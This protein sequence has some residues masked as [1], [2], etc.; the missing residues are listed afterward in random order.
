M[1]VSS[2]VAREKARRLDF[3]LKELA[4]KIDD[5]RL[6]IDNVRLDIR[7][8]GPRLTLCEIP[9][10]V[11]LEILQLV[12]TDMLRLTRM[13]HFKTIVNMSLVC[14]QFRRI[15]LSSS[16]LWAACT[17]TLHMPPHIIDMVVSR[18]GSNGI[19]VELMDRPRLSQELPLSSL[20]KLFEH[21]S[22]WRELEIELSDE[23]SQ[24]ILAHFPSEDLSTLVSLEQIPYDSPYFY[25]RPVSIYQD[26]MLP[27]L[28]ILDEWTWLPPLSFA[29]RVPN[30]IKCCLEST[31]SEFSK[32]FSFLNAIPRLEELQL[33]I[34]DE[35]TLV[36]STTLHLPA[37]KTLILRFSSEFKHG[38]LVGHTVRLFSC[39]GVKQF[40][41]F[42]N[43]SEDETLDSII[44]GWRRG[45]ASLRSLCPCLESFSLSLY[46]FRTREKMYFIDD[47]LQNLPRTIENIHLDI[48]SDLLLSHYHDLLPQ[49]SKSTHPCLTSLI[50]EHRNS[51]D[52]DFFTQVAAQL[53]LRNIRLKKL[54]HIRQWKE[55]K[56]TRNIFREAGVLYDENVPQ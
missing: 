5:V 37:L 55:V 26:W 36:Q 25:R 17:L 1:G 56:E 39:P 54:S 12:C 15:V 30:L 8:S 45:L 19:A 43:K 10:E 27:S 47:V 40:S 31:P 6:D 51:M 23:T 52:E 50:I 41:L 21:R 11:I 22:R 28:R 7:A 13:T 44:L 38:A 3:L 9:D 14:K 24:L 34:Y 53:K 18:S 20:I 4:S 46:D 2:T 42:L 29:S 49:A 48:R 35:S 33:R 16:N 32:L